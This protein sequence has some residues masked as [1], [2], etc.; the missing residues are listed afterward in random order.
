MTKKLIIILSSVIGFIILLILIIWLITIFKPTYYSYEKVETKIVNATRAYYKK[1][2]DLLPVVDGKYTLDYQTLVNEELIKPL[3]EIL[4]DGDNCSSTIYVVK[5][6][7]SYSYIPLLNCGDKYETKELYRKVL[8]D[9]NVVTSGSGLYL[10]NNGEY[11][12]RGKI[13]NNYVMLGTYENSNKRYDLYWKIISIGNDNTLRLQAIK[14]SADRTP[15]DDRYNIDKDQRSGYND[16]ELSVLKQFLEKLG[17]DK[18][19]F[20]AEERTLIVPQYLC[21]GKR[22]AD[23]KTRDGSVECSKQTSNKMIFSTILPYEYIRASLDENCQSLKDTSCI[24]YNYLVDDYA[25]SRWT[26]TGDPS[27]SYHAYSFTGETFESST[28]SNEKYVYLVTNLNEF[29]I[30]KG[31]NGTLEN[32]YRIVKKD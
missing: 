2:P 29:A 8:Q 27:D 11:Y 19:I 4:K 13:E 21:S 31:G 20:T 9:N 17:N 3:N 16:F 24:N 30:Y 18:D 1:Y 23:D 32:P 14:R 7:D 26:I 22:K 25:S 28:A 6:E 5:N 15:Y 10:S 12:F